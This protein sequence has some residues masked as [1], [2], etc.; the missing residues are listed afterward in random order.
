MDV[1][2]SHESRGA[3]SV[4]TGSE[5]HPLHAVLDEKARLSARM[6]SSVRGVTSANT[7]TSRPGVTWVRASDL[8]NMGGGRIAG[9]GIDFQA[10]LARRIRRAP[11]TAVRSMRDRADRLPPL[12]E[13][14]SLRERP[15]IARNGLERS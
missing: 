8:L 11:V 1:D 13:F 10:E 3:S 2:D 9:R 4:N 12:S 6:R 14:G 7:A 5:A 15:Q